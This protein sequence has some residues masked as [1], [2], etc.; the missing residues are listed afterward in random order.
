MGFVESGCQCERTVRE[1][2]VSVSVVRSY[3]TGI[4]VYV[5]VRVEVV[6][7]QWCLKVVAGRAALKNSGND[8]GDSF[9]FLRIEI[10]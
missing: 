4:Q 6:D 5:A 2:R 8:L 9:V 10:F 1:W 7:T 3:F